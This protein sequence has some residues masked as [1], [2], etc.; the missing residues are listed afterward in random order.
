MPLAD[1]APSATDLAAALQAITRQL[2]T[3]QGSEPG[4]PSTATIVAS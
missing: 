1:G 2:T 4:C 3:D